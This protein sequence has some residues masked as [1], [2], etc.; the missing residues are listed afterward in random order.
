[1]SRRRSGYTLVESL[2]AIAIIGVLIALLMPAVQQ[3]REAGRRIQCSN[4]LKQIILASA[5]YESAYGVTPVFHP[6][7]N[8]T[9]DASLFS[10]FARLLPFLEQ[11]AVYEAI[12]FSVP[13]SDVPG[14]TLDTPVLENLTPAMR[15]LSVFLCP[16]DSERN[17][18]APDL[19][20]G[21]YCAN[22]GWPQIIR[23]R[24][25]G[26][27]TIAFSTPPF[28]PAAYFTDQATNVKPKSISDGLSKTLAFSERLRNPGSMS[29]FMDQRRLYFQIVRP[30]DPLDWT[31]EGLTHLC[32]R[33]STP[34][35]YSDRL[36]GS[37]L[38]GD[39]RY[40]NMFTVLM[41]PNTKSCPDTFGQ[42]DYN[43]YFA[44][45]DTGVTPSS[46]HGD[47]VLVA[48]A[49]GSVSFVTSAIDR[50]VWWAMGSRDG[51]E[52]E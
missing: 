39:A 22:Y 27:A 23:R 32:R 2:V 8:K 1:M 11:D 51:G 28:A 21:S 6:S 30:T 24:V 47:G 35:D 36:G 34:Q 25:N 37:W 17:R 41:T 46:E 29:F 38:R 45:G 40:G 42:A 43:C 10:G 16:T 12:N 15:S 26:Y 7:W 44:S 33:S 20:D 50:K 3:A 5:N 4:N 13:G 14:P 31:M 48:M 19:G 9:T 49:D 18:R 52:A